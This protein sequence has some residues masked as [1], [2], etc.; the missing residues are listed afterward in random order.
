ML[1]PPLP[2]CPPSTPSTQISCE[3]SHSS[4][5]Q[6]VTLSS[7]SLHPPS[8]PSPDCAL[9]QPRS[10]ACSCLPSRHHLTSSSPMPTSTCPFASVLA[11]LQWTLCPISAPPAAH[12]CKTIHGTGSTAT[13]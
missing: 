13:A 9:S 6:S 12:R 5:L 8:A 1:T 2:P 3:S 10:Q 11:C 7:F 4:P